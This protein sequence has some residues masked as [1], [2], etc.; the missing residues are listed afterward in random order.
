MFD[1][2][3]ISFRCGKLI[4]EYILSKIYGDKFYI[5]FFYLYFF[6]F[7]ILFQTIRVH[8]EALELEYHPDCLYDRL[9]IRDGPHHS[10]PAIADLCG[11]HQSNLYL[12][13][14]DAILL[15]FHSDHI[16]PASGFKMTVETGN[17]QTVF[18]YFILRIT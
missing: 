8:L 4:V 12:S 5:K 15:E 10:S 3:C 7:H 16:I 1:D 14:S 9:V 13:T 2:H 18:N 11:Q 17:S 6:S